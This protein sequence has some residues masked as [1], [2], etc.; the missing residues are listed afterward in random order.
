MANPRTDATE[1]VYCG[2]PYETDD[3]IP[4]K[5]I[6]PKSARGFARFVLVP[7][8]CLCNQGFSRDDEYLMQLALGLGAEGTADATEIAQRVVRWGEKP[9]KAR[10]LGSITATLKPVQV[11]VNGQ[12]VKTLSYKMRHGRVLDSVCRM[13]R[14]LYY[15]VLGRRLPDG[16]TAVAYPHGVFDDHPEF[17]H[18]QQLLTACP[19]HTVGNDALTYRFRIFRDLPGF[20]VWSFDFFR[21]FHAVGLTVQEGETHTTFHIPA[22]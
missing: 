2:G 17:A 1:C 10:L 16:F 5:A 13:V 11:R 6:I 7:A 15:D 4:P 9:E 20:S 14:G 3:H 12:V 22:S 19:P 18:A 21:S 8:C